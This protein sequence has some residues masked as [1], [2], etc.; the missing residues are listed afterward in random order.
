MLLCKSI[1]RVP[2]LLSGCHTCPFELL[3]QYVVFSYPGA[4][5]LVVGLAVCLR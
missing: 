1:C 2:V 5:S 4:D 3:R